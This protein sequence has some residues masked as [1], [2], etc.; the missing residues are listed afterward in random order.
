MKTQTKHTYHGVVF[1]RIVEHPSFKALNKVDKKYGHY[2]LNND[3]LFLVKHA[4][5]G[6][7]SWQFTFSPDDLETLSAD[8]D[9]GNKTYVVLVCGNVTVCILHKRQFSK[10]LDIDSPCS[11]WIRVKIPAP[12][13]RM[14][15]SGSQNSLNYV[16][17]H[18]AFPR[19][20]FG[21][22]KKSM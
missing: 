18:N 4:G 19:V 2:Q 7:R 17:P 3:R 16:V 8:L 20:L 1:A 13:A 11:Q 12:R 15:L 9:K 21:E 22:K 5:S 6:T 14:R 10:L